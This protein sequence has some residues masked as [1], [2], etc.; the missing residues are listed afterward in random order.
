MKI[1][2][3]Y[4]SI[5]VLSVMLA[6][7][8]CR[9]NTSDKETE[10]RE[11]TEAERTIYIEKGKV[12]AG[13]TFKALSSNLQA[14]MKEGGVANAISYC[15]LQA[16]P[17]TDSL[18]KVHQVD[19]RRTTLKARNPKNAPDAAERA[20]LEDYAQAAGQGMEL[21]PR[22]ALLDD[23]TVV[24][25]APIKVNVFCLQCHGKL[26]ESL[27]ETDYAVIKEHYPGDEAVGYADGDLRGMWSIKFHRD[28][29]E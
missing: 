19:I 22:V 10:N 3:L 24:F 4:L 21:T 14:A 27:R 7:V 12:I 5:G 9:Q 18:S 23:Q 13:S 20:I 26:G 29:S 25:Y 1:K 11:L 2:L 17:L 8:S 16:Y 6:A 15:N 28:A